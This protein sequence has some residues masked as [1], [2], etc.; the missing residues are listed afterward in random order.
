MPVLLGDAYRDAH[1]RLDA[2]LRTLAALDPD[3]LGTA[4]PACPGWTVHAVVSHLAGLA[5]DAVAGRLSG[6]PDEAWTAGHVDARLGVPV[7]D[8]LAEW[9]PLVDPMVEALN[10][11]AVG[12]PPCADLLVHEGD[13]VEALGDEVPPIG[14]W[15]PVAT[16]LCGGWLKGLRVPGTLT[17]RVGDRELA[18]GTGDGPAA[19]VTIGPWE[20]FRGVFSRRSVDQMRA[21]DW[22]GDPEPWL[23][24]LCVFG[25]RTDDQPVAR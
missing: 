2:R 13:V 22:D 1:A 19:T 16:M 9:A 15:G 24:P 25:P 17:V 14:S 11:R 10:G 7:E 8:V 12:P 18:A 21:W 20:F 6:P 3:A 23:A 4:V 5:A